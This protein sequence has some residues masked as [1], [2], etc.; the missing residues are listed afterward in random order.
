MDPKKNN[1]GSKIP[2]NSTQRTNNRTNAPSF[3]KVF[4]PRCFK[5]KF[6]PKIL[7]VLKP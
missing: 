1:K 3:F 5:L 7:I 4:L 6:N 2:D